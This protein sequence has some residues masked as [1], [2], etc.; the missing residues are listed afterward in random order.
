MKDSSN[1]W[2][3]GALALFILFA[4]LFLLRQIPIF[5]PEGSRMTETVWMPGPEFTPTPNVNAPPLR[6]MAQQR[7]F[8]I[9]AAVAVEPLERDA[10]YAE[11]LAREFNVLTPENVM[12]FSF[13]QPQRSVFDFSQ[14]DKLVE[15]AAGHG[16]QVRG[17]TLVWHQQLPAWVNALG[18]DELETVLKEHIQTLVGHYRGRVF[19]WDVVNEALEE[20]GSRRQTLWQRCLGDDY[21]AKA[22][23]WANEADEQALLFYNDY[24]IEIPGAKS[25]A[26]YQLVK[27][28]LEAGAPIHGI[29]LQ[30]HLVNAPSPRYLE[31]YIKRF[32]ELGIQ[33]H[34]TELDVRLKQPVDAETLAWQALV[35]RDVLDVCLRSSNC[36]ALVT[37]GFTDRYSWI[38]DFFAGY[39][40]ALIFDGKY[41]PKP[42][43]WEFSRLLEGQ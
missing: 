15:F 2:K 18:C 5:Q 29:G 30:M 33:V 37:W 32:A 36:T 27:D 38:P 34:I 3:Y 14:A 39:G 21:L 42:A 17:H 6:E 20:N 35:Y 9:G 22:F 40:D 10:A 11:V 23:R 4:S 43:Y 1:L 8:L 28:L 41:Q 19:A 24:N 25:E 16:M 12:K 26:A 13:I 7:G 31:G